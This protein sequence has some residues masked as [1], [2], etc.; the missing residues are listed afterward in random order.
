MIKVPFLFIYLEK[1]CHDP[2]CPGVVLATSYSWYGVNEPSHGQEKNP[3]FFVLKSLLGVA[4][5]HRDGSST[6]WPW[7]GSNH[8]LG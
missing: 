4:L 5:G 1:L 3:N 8:L 2:V 6:L 7:G